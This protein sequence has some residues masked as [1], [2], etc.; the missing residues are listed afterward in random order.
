MARNYPYPH[1]L[2]SMSFNRFQMIYYP[3]YL[4]A[5]LSIAESFT[6]P[7]P[8]TLIPSKPNN[9]LQQQQQHQT[10][11]TPT[12]ES[13]SV[14]PSKTS[15]FRRIKFDLTTPTKNLLR[16]LHT[17]TQKNTLPFVLST[18]TTTIAAPS[19]AVADMKTDH[20]VRVALEPS[21]LLG[22][23]LT[24]RHAAVEDTVGTPKSAFAALKGLV[25]GHTE[26]DLDLPMT[27]TM[28][29]VVS[30]EEGKGVGKLSDWSKVV[31]MG[32]GETYYYNERTDVSTVTMPIMV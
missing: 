28:T 9:A 1:P 7:T 21:S 15:L 3:C 22:G 32:S 24:D 4:L 6:F 16:L 18:L 2:Q 31:N 30:V 20:A 17:A 13:T 25:G 10:H 19:L 12:D 11:S 14:V 8:T 23:F 27:T 26:V 5:I 29:T